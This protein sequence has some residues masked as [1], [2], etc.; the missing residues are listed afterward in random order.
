MIIILAQLNI[1][2]DA[3]SKA[4]PNNSRIVIQ[5]LKV[6]YVVTGYG[7]DFY[8]KLFAAFYGVLI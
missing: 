7:G 8:L 5:I 6:F 3:S 2:G 1:L 4:H